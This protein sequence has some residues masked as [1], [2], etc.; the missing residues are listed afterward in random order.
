[1]KKVFITL[2]LGTLILFGCSNQELPKKPISEPIPQPAPSS[3]STPTST[4]S[5]PA[6]AP[7]Y[8]DPVAKKSFKLESPKFDTKIVSPVA[9]SGQATGTMFFE[10]VFYIDLTDANGK[11]LGSGLASSTSDWTTVQFIP[12]KASII[13]KTPTTK[14]GFIILRNDNSSGLPENVH[15]AKFPISF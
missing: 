8:S 2:T 13:F 3:T 15:Y 4:T 7:E 10:G 11:S 9:I 12:F 14:T 1:M 6:P 5:T